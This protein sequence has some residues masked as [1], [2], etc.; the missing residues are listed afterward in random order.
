[1]IWSLQ[2]KVVLYL[3]LSAWILVTLVL[4]LLKKATYHGNNFMGTNFSEDTKFNQTKGENV[5][6]LISMHKALQYFL[7]AEDVP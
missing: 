7:T 6:Y 2:A 5:G 1:M 3:F 4:S